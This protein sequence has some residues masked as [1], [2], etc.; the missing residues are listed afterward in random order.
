MSNAI[1]VPWQIHDLLALYALNVAGTGLVALGWWGAGSQVEL[2]T[3]VGWV[4]V[5]ALG[6]VV[7]G[8]GNMLWVFAG[9]RAVGA[10]LARLVPDVRV[11][12]ARCGPTVAAANGSRRT[13][14]APT[15]ALSDARLESTPNRLV[16]AGSAHF[17]HQPNCVLVQDKHVRAS[18]RTSHERAGRRPCGMCEPFGAATGGKRDTRQRSAGDA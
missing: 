12:P 1:S 18:S 6:L 4:T 5:A 17:Y 9:R 16:A 3:Q 14:G 2:S 15:A 13:E 7:S 10:R 8:T 11:D